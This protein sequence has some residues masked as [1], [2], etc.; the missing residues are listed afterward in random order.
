[1]KEQFAAEKQGLEFYTE[2][3]GV[4]AKQDSEFV[5]KVKDKRLCQIAG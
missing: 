1:M 5:R 4:I 2:Y 3:I